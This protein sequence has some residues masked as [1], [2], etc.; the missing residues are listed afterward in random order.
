MLRL[1]GCGPRNRSG[2]MCSE[3]NRA[4]LESPD[5]SVDPDSGRWVTAPEY[6]SACRRERPQVGAAVSP[7]RFSFAAPTHG[8]RERVAQPGLLARR[9]IGFCVEKAPNGKRRDRFR[10]RRHVTK[11]A[12]P[13]RLGST[14][15]PLRRWSPFSPN[16]G[17]FLPMFR[18][19]HL[20]PGRLL[21]IVIQGSGARNPTTV[22]SW[23]QPMV[24]PPP[25][26]E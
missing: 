7:W 21:V 8:K 26:A 23:Q 12:N 1:P 4:T 19:V 22:F 13:L 16:H 24:A 5:R 14:P 6:R 10:P 15:N 20:P 11:F 17:R 25:A 9:M 2:V 3:I 18:G